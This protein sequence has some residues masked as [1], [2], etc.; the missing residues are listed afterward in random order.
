MDNNIF[1]KMLIDE[2][3]AKAKEKFPIVRRSWKWYLIPVAMYISTTFH[4][5]TKAVLHKLELLG[6]RT[7]PKLIIYSEFSILSSNFCRFIW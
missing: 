2:A 7:R 4:S 1:V 6:L 3:K 5:K